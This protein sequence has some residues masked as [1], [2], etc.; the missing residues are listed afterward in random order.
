MKEIVDEKAPRPV[1]AYSQAIEHNGTLFISGQIALRAGESEITTNSVGQQAHLVMENLG[2][3]LNAAGSSYQNLIKCSIFLVN[4]ED[5]PQVNEI[6]QEYL[7][8]PL[9]ARETVAV[10]ALPKGALVE[11]SAVAAMNE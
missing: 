11:I 2:K 8:P 5:F 6:Y 7:Q 10:S 4:M 9:P 3:I 1:G